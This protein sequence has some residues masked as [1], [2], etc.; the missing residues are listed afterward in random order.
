MSCPY[1]CDH[2]YTQTA[3]DVG[4]TFTIPPPFTTLTLG[5]TPEEHAHLAGRC[6][7]CG[8]IS[9]SPHGQYEIAQL[10]VLHRVGV[11]DPSSVFGIGCQKAIAAYEAELDAA[12]AARVDEEIA[13]FEAEW[14]NAQEEA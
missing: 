9:C 7:V 11:F 13:Q 10:Y 3:R 14:G 5:I 2:C 6:Q 4:H 12:F 8:E 1:D